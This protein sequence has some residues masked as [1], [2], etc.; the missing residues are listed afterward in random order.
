MRIAVLSDIHDN[1]WKLAAA[2]DAVAHADALICCGDLCSPF[3]VHQ[4]GRGFSKP[5][6]VVFGNNDGDRFRIAANARQYEHIRIHGELFRGEFDGQRVAVNHYDHIARA[7]AA[8]GEFDVV[9]Y[10]HNHVY[11]VARLGRTLAINPGAIMG[12]AFSADGGRTDVASTFAIYDTASR[13]AAGFEV[14]GPLL[15]VPKL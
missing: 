10:G 4:L 9:C 7:I 13:E 2:L 14:S 5:I 3:I 8:S 15:V 12:A 11:G 1:V 6:H